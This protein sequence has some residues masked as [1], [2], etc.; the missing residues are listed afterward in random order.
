MY[1]HIHHMKRTQIYLKDEQ[2]QLLERR[3]K[4]AGLTKSAVIR[5]AIDAFLARKQEKAELQTALDETA[6]SLPGLK[7]P[8]RDEWERGYG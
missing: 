6:G 5:Q 1:T 4:A 2:D 8:G 3:A 7:V